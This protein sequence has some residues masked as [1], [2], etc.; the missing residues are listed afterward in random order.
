MFYKNHQYGCPIP[1]NQQTGSTDP[2]IF[3]DAGIKNYK[4]SG[5]RIRYTRK[6]QFN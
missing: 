1:S 5:S 3:P 4:S 2:A 6:D